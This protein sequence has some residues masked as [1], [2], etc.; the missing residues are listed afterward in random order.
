MLI[1]GRLQE[2]IGHAGSRTVVSPSD[3]DEG[4]S[5]QEGVIQH[6]EPYYVCMY[7]RVCTHSFVILWCA[8]LRVCVLVVTA[9]AH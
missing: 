2:N 7:V 1:H 9:S 4:N 3:L 5:S 8:T 6:L